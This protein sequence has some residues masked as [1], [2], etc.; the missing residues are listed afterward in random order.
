MGRW[1]QQ[2]GKH[3]FVPA[4]SIQHFRRNANGDH[5]YCSRGA[6]TDNTCSFC[7]LQWPTAIS[8]VCVRRRCVAKLRAITRNRLFI[9]VQWN[10]RAN[11]SVA[12]WHLGLDSTN[13]R[14]VKYWCDV[15]ERSDEPADMV[16]ISV[17]YRTFWSPRSSI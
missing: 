9:L 3:Y 7:K 13:S 1:P 8:R 12:T 5:V 6:G 16:V 17:Y 15:V 10:Y 14:L 11:R 2:R 4:S